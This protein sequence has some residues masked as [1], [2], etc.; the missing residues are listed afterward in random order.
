MLRI[1]KENFGFAREMMTCVSRQ[2]YGLVQDIESY[3]LP[4]RQRLAIY[5][6]RQRQNNAADDIKLVA[7]KALIASRLS[8]TP[9]TLSRLLHDFSDE[10]LIEVA[11]RHIKILDEKKMAALFS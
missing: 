1:A 10:G 4:A 5:L 2:F 6:L 9:E 3:S 8:L 11:G 7:N